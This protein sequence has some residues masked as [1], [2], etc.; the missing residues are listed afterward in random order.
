[1]KIKL[2]AQSIKNVQGGGEEAKQLNV[3]TLFV[4][5]TEES[6]K[7]LASVSNSGSLLS[8]VSLYN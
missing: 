8:P 5:R 3:A 4:V 1:M 2:S 6:E 7:G